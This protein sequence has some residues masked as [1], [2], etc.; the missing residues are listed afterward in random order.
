[1]KK[2]L[3]TSALVLLCL[4]ANAQSLQVKD[5]ANSVGSWEGNLTYLDYTSGKPFTMLANIKISLTAD[6][7]GYIMAYEYPKEPHANAKDTTAI[8]GSLFGN[9]KIIEFKRDSADGFTLVTEVD[10]EDGNENKKAILRHQYLFL[11]NTFTITK[12][13]KFQGTDKWIKRN[14]YLLTRAEI[15]PEISFLN[16]CKDIYHLSLIIY[17]PDGKIQTRVSD[18]APDQIKTY[19]LPVATE[20]FIADGKQEAFAMKGNDIKATGVTPYLVLKESDAKRVIK[21]GTIAQKPAKMYRIAKIK[22]DGNQLEKYKSALQE[23]MDAAIK[24]EPG[25][26]SYTAVSD[27]KDPSVIT[28]FEV[29]ASP[30]AYQAH[31][32]APHFKKYK[33]TVKDIVLSLELIDTELVVRAEKA[34]Y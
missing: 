7:K 4:F 9:D 34:D 5:L 32:S 25:V 20:I 23:Q 33:E 14:E 3:L 24:L 18:L 8:V 19:S 30:E 27:K 6:K 26:L 28:I 12:S 1:M 11:K 22:V 10:G 21:T 29:Y 15:K 17:T 13:V 31:T 2:I 16:D